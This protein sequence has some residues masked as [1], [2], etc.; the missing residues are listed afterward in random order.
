MLP[1]PVQHGCDACCRAAGSTKKGEHGSGSKAQKLS[2]PEPP[3]QRKGSGKEGRA[4]AEPSGRA[5]ASTG[6]SGKGEGKAAVTQA[7]DKPGK[8]PD[9]ELRPKGKHAAESGHASKPARALRSG[10]D[11]HKQ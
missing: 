7:A 1:L 3:P 2:Q 8:S 11:Q 9:A 6:D 4:Q 10:Q 5:K